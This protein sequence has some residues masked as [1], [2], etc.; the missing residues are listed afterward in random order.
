MNH[1]RNN[2]GISLLEVLV[3]IAIIGVMSGGVVMTFH[4]VHTIKP[5]SCAKSIDSC[6]EEVKSEAMSKGTPP[7]LVLY[8]SED[9]EH[10]GYYAA[11]TTSLET[12]TKQPE[13]DT[14]VSDKDV[15]I[16]VT[17]TDKTVIDIAKNDV[18]ITF[19]RAAGSVKECYVATKGNVPER[20]KPPE[21]IRITGGGRE[22]SIH[23]VAETGKHFVE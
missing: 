23:I 6:L 15:M 4:M 21:L 8:Q 20:R 18:L 9:S 11:R 1:I 12:Y 10:P 16:E 2:K 22:S 14:K 19:D 13:Y 5:S 3:V 7:Y 17:L